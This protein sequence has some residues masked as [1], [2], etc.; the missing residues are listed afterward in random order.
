MILRKIN[1]MDTRTIFFIGKPGCGKGTQA[2][3]LSETTGWRVISA[4]DQFRALAGEESILG[5]KVKKEIDSGALA[6]DWLAMHLYLTSLLNLADESSVIFDGFCRE[7]SQ[8]E[9]VVKSLAW[10]RRPFVVLNIAVSDES[11]RRRLSLRAE[12][13]G[14]VDDEVIEERIKEYYAHTEP[15]IEFFKNKGVLI[16]INGEQTPEEIAVDIRAAL[17]IK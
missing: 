14:R 17:T 10:L 12:T 11:V 2:K 1:N 13:S 6:P 7:V 3:L 16:E 9:L 8:A 5:K 15:A 4:G